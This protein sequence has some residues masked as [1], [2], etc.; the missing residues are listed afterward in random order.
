MP[1]KEQ[2][3]QPY[4][5]PGEYILINKTNRKKKRIYI[6]SRDEYDMQLRIHNYKFQKRQA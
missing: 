4:T 5:S 3:T 1:L 6:H 2:F